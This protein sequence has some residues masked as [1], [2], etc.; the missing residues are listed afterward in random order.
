L[1]KTFGCGYTARNKHQALLS[2]LLYC[3]PC[4]ARMVYAWAGTEG[5]KYPYYRCLNAQRKGSAACAGRSVSA[6]P[7]E[8]SVLGQLQDAHPAIAVASSDGEEFDRVRQVQ[9]IQ[10]VVE[11]IGYDGRSGKVSIRFRIAE[12]APV[13][14]TTEP[15]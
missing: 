4:G 14:T 8:Q 3:E 7:I 5:R 1:I 13:I 10:A 6:Y 11:R 9:A 2:G 15:G 12:S